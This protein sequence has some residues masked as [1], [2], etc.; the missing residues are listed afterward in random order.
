MFKRRNKNRVYNVNTNLRFNVLTVFMYIK[1]ILS[2][3]KVG[4]TVRISIAIYK[5][6]VPIQKSF[7][8]V[9]FILWIVTQN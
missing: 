6:S 8:S 7:L 3:I 5:R 9:F 1:E 4:T 2:L